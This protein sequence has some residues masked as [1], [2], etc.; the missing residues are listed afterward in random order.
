MYR[1]PRLLHRELRGGGG[2]A[3]RRRRVQGEARL[4]PVHALRMAIGH[5]DHRGAIEGGTRDAG[6][7][8][9]DAGTWRGEGHA[10]RAHEVACHRRHD[11]RRGLVVRQHDGQPTPPRRLD[12]GELRA[13]AR[14]A[15]DPRRPGTLEAVDD[16]V[17][18]GRRAHAFARLSKTGRIRSSA[19]RRFASEFAYE[20]RRYPSPWAP[21]AV[22]ASTATPASL[23]SRSATSA[24]VRAVASMLGN[25]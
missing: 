14:H 24:D 23:R 1:P 17:G 19:E 6:R 20:R 9:G 12:E 16:H 4:A 10:R 7:R 15:E 11:A 3:R 2:P 5:E 22:P 18:D 8:R 25:T 21:N 13:T